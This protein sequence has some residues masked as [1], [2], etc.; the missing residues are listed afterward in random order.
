MTPRSEEIEIEAAFK[1]IEAELL[2]IRA[3]ALHLG[4]GKEWEETNRKLQELKEFYRKT[5][6]LEF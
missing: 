4:L 5:G 3:A 6:L 2:K 1:C